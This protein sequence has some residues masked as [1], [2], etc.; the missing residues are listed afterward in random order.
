M[1]DARE[2]MPVGGGD[3]GSEVQQRAGVVK[4]RAGELLGQQVAQQKDRLVDQVDGVGR[5]LRRVADSLRDE[6]GSPI[7]GYVEKAADR[8][9]DF[10]RGLRGKQPVD[11]LRSAESYARR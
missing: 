6:G 8:F 2:S 7:A 1:D 4:E 5:A 3:L 9:D 10:T 11:L